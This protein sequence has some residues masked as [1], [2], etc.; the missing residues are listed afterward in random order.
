MT[1]TIYDSNNG[2]IILIGID[3]GI[4][5]LNKEN[6]VRYTSNCVYVGTTYSGAFIE[7]YFTGGQCHEFDWERRDKVFRLEDYLKTW[8]LTPDDLKGQMRMNLGDI[9]N[10]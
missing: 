10:E 2:K 1:P 3:R 5:Y 8:A 9:D 6:K 4:Y 7:T